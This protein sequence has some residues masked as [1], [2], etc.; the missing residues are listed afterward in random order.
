MSFISFWNAISKIVPGNPLSGREAELARLNPDKIYLENVRS[1]LGVSSPVAQRICE[2]AVRRGLLQKRVEVVCPDGSIAASGD[3]EAN[4]PPTVTF[5]KEDQGDLEP[6]EMAT[7]S[8]QKAVFY[9][10]NG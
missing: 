5:W 3:S 6:V 7:A 8:L 2:T 10:L 9:R 4:L 1:V